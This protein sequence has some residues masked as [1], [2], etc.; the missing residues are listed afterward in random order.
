MIA[1]FGVVAV[2]GAARVH[3]VAP[4]FDD[5]AVAAGVDPSTSATPAPFLTDPATLTAGAQ[6][7]SLAAVLLAVNNLRDVDTDRR[8][9][10]RTLAVLLGEG[11]VRREI[12]ALLLAPF[13]ANAWWAR[14]FVLVDALS[15]IH[16]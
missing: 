7:G 6:V 8:A 1:M 2:A 16:I 9:G 14:R 4:P 3:R 13:L 11:F 5:T 15:L 10:K 12:Y